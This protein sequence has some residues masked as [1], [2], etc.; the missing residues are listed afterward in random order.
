MVALVIGLSVG[1]HV[2]KKAEKTN[3][4]EKVETSNEAQL[5]VEDEFAKIDKNVSAVVPA[6]DL[7]VTHLV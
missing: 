7:N 4:N 3:K 1:L 5:S 2:Q 6:S